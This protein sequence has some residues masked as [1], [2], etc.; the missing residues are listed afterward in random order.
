[1]SQS[2]RQ[3][4]HSNGFSKSSVDSDAAT[5]QPPYGPVVEV[6]LARKV[7]VDRS[8]ADNPAGGV[9]G[10]SSSCGMPWRMRVGLMR[11]KAGAKSLIRS[12]CPPMPTPPTPARHQ[13]ELETCRDRTSL[14]SATQRSALQAC[15]SGPA[16]RTKSAQP[17]DAGCAHCQLSCMIHT[18]KLDGAGDGVT[19]MRPPTSIRCG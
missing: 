16:E 15:L 13:H 19:D 10:V 17:L 14:R 5:A 11:C 7:D 12:H 4:E 3:T 2:S 6:L 9:A 8:M 1:M 18:P